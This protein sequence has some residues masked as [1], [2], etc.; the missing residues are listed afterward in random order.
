MYR[1]AHPLFLTCETPL[2]AGSGSDL[3]IID[4]PIQRERHTGFPKMEGSGLKGSMR[5]AVERKIK[6]NPADEWAFSS[7]DDPDVCIHRIFGYDDGSLKSGKNGQPGEKE[8]LKE[9]FKRGK[10]YETSFAG[11]ISFSDARL[12]LFPV[13]SMKGVFAWITCPKALQQ[14]KKDM[15]LAGVTGIT[16]PSSEGIVA[17][18]NKITVQAGSQKKVLLEEYAFDV[19]EDDSVNAFGDWLSDNIF[20]DADAY[21]KDKVKTDIVVLP[22]DEFKDFVNLSTE[23]I[24]RTKIDNSTG[25]VAKGQLFTEEYLPAE[26]VLYSL[27]LAAPEFTS[28]DKPMDQGEVIKF[29]GEHLPPIIQAGANATLGKGLLKTK[30]ITNKKG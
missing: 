17:K 4:L 24:T 28:K 27:V 22:N 12:L 29:I 3:G 9:H 16:I 30:L 18:G 10:D 11:S 2:H 21:W 14:F 6:S 23:V 20:Q 8:R 13:K 15:D 19:Q 7:Y 26:S 1:T 5:E 25:T